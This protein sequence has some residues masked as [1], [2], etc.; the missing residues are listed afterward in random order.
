MIFRLIDTIVAAVAAAFV[1]ATAVCICLNV[2][3]RYV[4]ES[5]LV[6][7]DEIPGYF[8]VWIAFLGAYLAVR[9]RG[10]ISF[11]MLMDKLPERPRRLAAVAVN[12]LV[13]GFFCLLLVLSVK[14]ISIV[15]DTEIET[16]EIPQGV[17]MAVLPIA[18]VA[19]I[20]GLAADAVKRWRE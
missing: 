2:F 11:D 7:A 1:A 5:G 6:W 13:I 17:F 15:G 9:S 14:M 12:L 10:H 20:A 4:L 16:A 3:Y 8:L 18:C 19:L